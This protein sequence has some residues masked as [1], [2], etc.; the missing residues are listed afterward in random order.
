VLLTVVT[1]L[2]YLTG[3][4]GTLY[5]IVALGLDIGFL[6]FATRLSLGHGDNLPMRTFGYSIW[7]LM[8]IFAALLGDHYLR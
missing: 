6:V 1:V 2:P 5:L 8:G 4:S 7:Y 3:M